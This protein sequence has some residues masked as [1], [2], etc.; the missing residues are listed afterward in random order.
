[1]FLTLGIAVGSIFLPRLGDT[2]GRRSVLSVAIALTMPLIYI[3][4][5]VTTASVAYATTFFW[6]FTCICRYTILF[7]WASE[8]FPPGHGSHSITALRATISVTFFCMNLY[9]M[10]LSQ[11]YIPVF[12]LAF[13]LSILVLFAA[14]VM[15]ESPKW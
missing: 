12:Q 8:L 6:G 5:H 3:A 13:V 14:F 4:M 2:Y 15:P 10:F 7:V 1:M 9:F 11:S